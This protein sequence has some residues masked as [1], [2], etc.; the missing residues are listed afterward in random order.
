MAAEKT[1]WRLK[2]EDPDSIKRPSYQIIWGEADQGSKGSDLRFQKGRN[3]K[4][5]L[6]AWWGARIDSHDFMQEVAEKAAARFVVEK[7]ISEEQL[8]NCQ[9]ELRLS[10]LTAPEKLL[11]IFPQPDLVSGREDDLH[12]C[13]RNQRQKLLRPI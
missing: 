4:L 2:D 12:W 10:V 1:I 8:Q 7:E 11:P 6:S 9:K 3:Q 13:D 5:F